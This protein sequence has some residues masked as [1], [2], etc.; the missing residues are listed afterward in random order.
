MPRLEDTVSMVVDRTLFSV[1]SSAF[2]LR[3]PT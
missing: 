3:S 2:G 1:P